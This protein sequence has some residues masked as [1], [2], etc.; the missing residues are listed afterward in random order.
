MKKFIYIFKNLIQWD[1]I[2]A[3]ITAMKYFLFRPRVTIN[4]PSEK[5]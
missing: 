2:K 4:Y 3:F 5:G 1:F